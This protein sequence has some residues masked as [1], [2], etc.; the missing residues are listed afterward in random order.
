[1]LQGAL[2]T[3]SPGPTGTSIDT[4]SALAHLLE[5]KNRHR[6][7]LDPS[8]TERFNDLGGDEGFGVMNYRLGRPTEPLPFDPLRTYR[9]PHAHAWWI[10]IVTPAGVT[11][12]RKITL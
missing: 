12:S 6:R 10:C 5:H 9:A 4:K 7:K 1:M 3:S 8:T 11:I 2:L